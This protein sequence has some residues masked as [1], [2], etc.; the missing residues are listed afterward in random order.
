[1]PS[2]F[3]TAGSATKNKT[4]I[5]EAMS[6][7]RS[8]GNTRATAFVEAMPNGLARVRLNFLNSKTSS[9]FYGQGSKN[10]RP[11]LDPVTYKIAWD[12]IDEAI[13]V[14]NATN[15]P[16]RPSTPANATAAPVA[17]SVPVTAGTSVTISPIPILSKTEAGPSSP[18]KSNVPAAV[19]P[20]LVPVPAES[21][22]K[23]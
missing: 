23:K 3:I 22:L 21:S 15:A 17:I 5:W 4:S 18:Q 16:A 7:Q 19:A 13:F 2:G 1:M 14:R 11:I 6:Y 10:D 12:K 9:G 20:A 8:S